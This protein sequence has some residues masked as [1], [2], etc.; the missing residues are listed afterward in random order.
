M[1]KRSRARGEQMELTPEL[2]VIEGTF[3]E[4]A[5]R[6]LSACFLNGAEHVILDFGQARAIHDCAL[7][8]LAAEISGAD[9]PTVSVRGLSLHHERMLRYLGVGL[10]PIPPPSDDR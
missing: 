9:A 6:A 1:Q 7:A 2:V 4:A 3:D 5:A 10:A 8:R